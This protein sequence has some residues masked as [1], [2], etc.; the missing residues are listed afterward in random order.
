[1]FDERIFTG[2]TWIQY[3]SLFLVYVNLDSQ[4]IKKIKTPVCLRSD[5][6]AG[7]LV[8]EEGKLDLVSASEDNFHDSLGV[9]PA[10]AE[11]VSN[12]HSS[13]SDRR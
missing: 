9:L 8:R 2:K 7:K 5:E 4:K 13:R 12:A 11:L 3:Y 10:A 6:A 1:M